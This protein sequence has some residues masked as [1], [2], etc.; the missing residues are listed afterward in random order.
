MVKIKLLLFLLIPFCSFSQEMIFRGKVLANTDDLKGILIVNLTKETQTQTDSLGQFR[1]KA[2][3]DDLL[4]F[5]AVHL[6]KV[7]HLVEKT[8]FEKENLIPM[9]VKAEMLDVVEI[10]RYNFNPEDLG[11]VPRGQKRLTVGER[12]LYTAQTEQ[13]LG[14]LI[15]AISGRTKMLKQ[16][17]EMEREDKRVVALSNAFL[18]EFFTN[19]LNIQPENVEEFKYFAVYRLR[20]TNLPRKQLELRLIELA[21]EYL[22]LRETLED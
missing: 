9:E 10:V 17:L 15:N 16:L 1:I 8:D 13:H 18:D 22:K 21:E 11:I 14:A 6:W 5:T 4:I 2:E 12:R 7:R 19:S 20:K 3:E